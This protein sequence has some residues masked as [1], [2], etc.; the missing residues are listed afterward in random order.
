MPFGCGTDAGFRLGLGVSML[1]RCHAPISL[2]RALPL[3]AVCAGAVR[4]RATATTR[5]IPQAIVFLRERSSAH[6][7]LMEWR[8][9]GAL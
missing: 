5:T 1:T 3:F 6:Q 2:S 4:L 8:V 9:A 7:R